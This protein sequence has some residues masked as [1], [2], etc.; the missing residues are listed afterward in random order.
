M[1]LSKPITSMAPNRAGKGYWLIASDGGVFGF[2]GVKFYGNPL[3]R[4]VHKTVARL[5]ATDTGAGY[6]ILATD[7]SVYAFGDAP[8]RGWI[9][10]PNADDIAAK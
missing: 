9:S 7:G 2:G 8:N 1:H 10:Q 5:R 6:W 3:T 4:G